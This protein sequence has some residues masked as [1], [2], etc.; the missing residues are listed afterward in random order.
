MAEGVMTV[1][2]HQEAMR[3]PDAKPVPGWVVEVNEVGIF[4]TGIGADFWLDHILFR[5]IGDRIRWQSLCPQGG[6]AHIPCADKEEAEFVLSMMLQHGMHKG[7][8]K[9]R[10]IKAAVASR[11]VA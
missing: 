11:E 4:A 7:H 1:T 8:A 6:V 3:F 9:V 10:R 5:P 2:E